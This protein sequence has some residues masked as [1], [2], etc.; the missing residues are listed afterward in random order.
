MTLDEYIKR[1]K[2]IKKEHGGNL[3]VIYSQDEEGNAFN[4]VVYEPAVGFYKDREWIDVGNITDLH[5]INS[6]CVN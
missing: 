6:V 4:K 3:E 1:L 5:K 2:E